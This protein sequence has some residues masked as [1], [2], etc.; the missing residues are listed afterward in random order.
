MGKGECFIF[1][2]FVI[3][4]TVWP[5]LDGAQSLS[6]FLHGVPEWQS[7]HTTCKQDGSVEWGVTSFMTVR[8]VQLGTSVI[9][10]FLWCAVLLLNYN[11]LFFLTC[12]CKTTFFNGKCRFQWLVLI[13]VLFHDNSLFYIL[14]QNISVFRRLPGCVLQSRFIIQIHFKNRAKYRTH[15]FARL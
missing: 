9:Y 5:D 4:L 2:R 11:F 6:Y 1:T 3:Y 7:G 13:A 15:H 8:R 12:R 14:G 10:I